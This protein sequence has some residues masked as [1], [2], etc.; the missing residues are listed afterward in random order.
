MI[1]RVFPLVMA[2][3]LCVSS[4]VIANQLL[5][6]TPGSAPTSSI[7]PERLR[8]TENRFELSASQ[9]PASQAEPAHTN[10]VD[11]LD[12]S[13]KFHAQV[14]SFSQPNL[15]PSMHIGI[16]NNGLQAQPHTYTNPMF[17]NNAGAF[18]SG[19]INQQM[20]MVPQQMMMPQQQQQ[21]MMYNNATM[22][23]GNHMMHCNG[24]HCQG[25]APSN[26]NGQMNTQ[27]IGAV[28]AAVMLGSFI[29]NGGIGGVMRSVGWDNRRRILGPGGG[30]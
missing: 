21:M 10:G 1:R 15:Q 29:Q 8:P 24:M 25:Q 27:I 14:N 13:L 19:G 30:Y 5:E 26:N 9:A 22:C 18:Q 7:K 17:F 23:N 11:I 16:N 20:L 2:I 4:P 6:E 3:P 12:E 28:G